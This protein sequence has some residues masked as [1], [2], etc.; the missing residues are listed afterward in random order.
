LIKRIHL[1]ELIFR[2]TLGIRWT[3]LSTFYDPRTGL[4]YIQ[5]K[6]S[7]R[8]K[9]YTIQVY[10]GYVFPRCK[11]YRIELIGISDHWIEVYASTDGSHYSKP[12]QPLPDPEPEPEP[13][14]ESIESVLD[15]LINSEGIPWLL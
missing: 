14:E 12:M 2:D 13:E 11:K 9:P 8:I 1:N 10:E 6:L 7:S 5:V 15:S 4:D 3:I